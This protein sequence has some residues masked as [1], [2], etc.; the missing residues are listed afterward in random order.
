MIAAMQILR[1]RAA[2][3]AL[4][5][6]VAMLFATPLR[7]LWARDAG[8]WWLPFAVWAPIVAAMAWLVR[9]PDAR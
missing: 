5:A 8:P 6:L 3:V 1:S 9:D 7:G 2:A 4:V